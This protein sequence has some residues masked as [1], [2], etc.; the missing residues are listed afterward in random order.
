M[1]VLQTLLLQNNRHVELVSFYRSHGRHESALECLASLE[2]SAHGIGN[3]ETVKYLQQLGLNP[4][5]SALVLKFSRRLLNESR[6][7]S[8]QGLRIFTFPGCAIPPRDVLNHLKATTKG[9]IDILIAYL[10]AIIQVGMR[11]VKKG[12]K[13][14]KKATISIDSSWVFLFVFFF[15]FLTVTAREHGRRVSQRS[16]FLVPGGHPQ[17]EAHRG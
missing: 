7:S 10:E 15:S 6:S 3:E 16:D 11:P 8:D 5:H 1:R 12:R 17:Q 14:K 13:K 4:Q 9:D 2:K